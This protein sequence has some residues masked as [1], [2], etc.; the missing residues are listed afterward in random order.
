MAALAVLYDVHGNQPALAAV[1][2]DARSAGSEGFVLGGDYALFGP[3]PAETVA[4]L[5]A[6][7]HARL[8]R[9]NVDRWSAHPEQAPED[10]LIRDAIAA[11]RETLG[12]AAVSKLDG[13]PE[14][15]ALDGTLYCHASPVSDVRSF[16]PT[17]AFEDDELL[18]GVPERRVV[19][20][21]THLQ[22]RRRRDDG[23]ELVNPGSVGMPFDGD[24][25]A[26]YAL[27]HPDGSI[28]HRRVGYDHE[29][30]AAAML[31]RFGDVP[32]A[33]RSSDRLLR[34]RL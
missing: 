9:G 20:G 7:S 1:L 22:F 14:Q 33:R 11:C 13:L 31:G 19:F 26:A 28:E 10:E 21:H 29:A 6:L 34:A 30:A 8:I 27:V 15:L 5:E 4:I 24:P 25:R 32:W 23:V 18:A 12:D 2:A 3:F 16:Q 17:P